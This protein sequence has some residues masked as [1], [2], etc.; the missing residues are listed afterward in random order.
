VALPTRQRSEPSRTGCGPW[1][2]Q[3]TSPPVAEQ[4]RFIRSLNRL[5]PSF[6]GGPDPALR[7]DSRPPTTRTL[8]MPSTSRPRQFTAQPAQKKKTR[9]ALCRSLPRRTATGINSTQ[10]QRRAKNRAALKQLPAIVRQLAEDYAQKA[11]LRPPPKNHSWQPNQNPRSPNHSQGA[12]QLAGSLVGTAG[13]IGGRRTNK[14]ASTPAS[15][16]R[17]LARRESRQIAALSAAPGN[18]R[19]PPTQTTL[20]MAASF[21]YCHPNLID[22]ILF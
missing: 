14:P 9:G 5:V 2:S 10:R 15:Q 4:A 6:A 19:R 21:K 13:K 1:R 8:V 18:G 17:R 7:G 20:A 3:F 12:P 11:A 22:L 16:T